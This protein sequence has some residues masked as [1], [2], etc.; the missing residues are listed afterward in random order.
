VKVLV[1]TNRVPFVH[2]GAEELCDHLVRNLLAAGVEA[3]AFRIPFTWDPPERLIDEMLIARRLRL[4]NVDRVIALKFPVYLVPWP[5]KVLWLLHQ[6]RQAYDLFDS[7]QSNIPDDSRGAEILTAIHRADGLAFA[8][9]RQIYTSGPAT[10]RRLLRYNNVVGQ[11]LRAPLNDPVL[12]GG[13]EAQGYILATGRVNAAKRQHLLVEALRHELHVRLIIAGPPDTPADAARL[14]DAVA[15]AG[16]EHQVKLDLRL[17]PRGEIA[18]LVNGATAVAYL[19]FDEDSL[20]YCTM[21]ALRAGKPVLTTS[22]AGGVLD[23][24]EDGVTGIV[25]HPE[26]EF[27]G[28]AMAKLSANPD[29]AARLGLAGRAALLEQNLTWPATIEALLS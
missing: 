2:G 14:R 29:L 27:L 21:E 19:P 1:L 16:M 4:F 10:A 20:G 7:G 17:L 15:E 23:I 3:E 12:F 5:D 24:I 28:V 13:G 6:Y 25:S 26:P 22:D 8:E 18:R 11:V 9:A